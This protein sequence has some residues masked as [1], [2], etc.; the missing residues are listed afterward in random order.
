M[1]GILDNP[2]WHA[3]TGPQAAW[4]L[5]RGH[6]VRFM[7][8]AAPFFALD[9]L[10]ADGL[11]DLAELVRQEPAAPL[12]LPSHV[13]AAAGLEARLFLPRAVSTPPG[14]RKTFEKPLVQMLLL[15]VPRAK[16]LDEP[17]IELG[18]D[19]AAD[20][21]ALAKRAEPGPFGPRTR[22]LG[23]F[24]GIRRKGQLVAMAGER[25]RLPGFTE[26]S[27]IA[28]DPEHRGRGY[29]GALTA[30]LA[31]RIQATGAVPFLHVFPDNPAAALYR[32]LGFSERRSL[33][34]TWLQ[35]L[36]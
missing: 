18:P 12:V 29:G 31:T 36:V 19:D 1:T 25:M 23:T 35:L 32:A 34:V 5:R 11:L 6:A 24:L 10:G 21:L 27:A 7:P 9:D 28:T 30:A 22:E 20:I 17:I 13:P 33:T 26:I 15:D 14:W 16:T 8:E 2:I 3:L 4:A